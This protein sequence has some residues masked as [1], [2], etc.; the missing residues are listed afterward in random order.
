MDFQKYISKPRLWL[1]RKAP[2][3][4]RRRIALFKRA[5]LDRRG[6]AGLIVTPQSPRADASYLP[7]IIAQQPI[8]QSE[9]TSGK[10]ENLR[11]AAARLSR[12]SVAP[13]QIFSFW[14]LVG[15]PTRAGGFQVGRSIVQDRLVAEVGGGLC[16]ISGLAY[17]LALRAGMTI[18]ERFPHS[19]DLYTEETRFTPLG[20]DATVVH[21]F[22]D[23][24]FCNDGKFPVAFEFAVEDAEIRGALISPAPLAEWRIDITRSENEGNRRRA[25]VSRTDPDGGVHAVSTSLYVVD[26][27]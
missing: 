5:L 18:L 2:E 26:T 15:P 3:P 10:I 12:V 19:R 9:H 20:L 23:L 27:A 8:R 24:R 1:R 14:S 11:L 21:G 17:E 22:K 13:G 25:A 16:Q 4:L 7:Q 6:A